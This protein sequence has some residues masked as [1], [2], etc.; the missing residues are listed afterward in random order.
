MNRWLQLSIDQLRAG[1]KVD[2]PSAYLGH[3]TAHGFS[4]KGGPFLQVGQCRDWTLGLADGSRLHA[5]LDCE[6]GRILVHR[7]RFDPSR[8]LL[9]AIAHLVA[10]TPA[11]PIL[12]LMGLAFAVSRMK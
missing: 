8:G 5:H 7:D 2:W 10:E 12:G 6:T 9:H 4:T 11:G 1:K 3:P